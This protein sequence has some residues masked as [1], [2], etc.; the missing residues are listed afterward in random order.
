MTASVAPVGDFHRRCS[1]LQP[2]DI[3][4]S[5]RSAQHHSQ[6]SARGRGGTWSGKRKSPITRGG[7]SHACVQQTEHAMTIE[8]STPGPSL[9]RFKWPRAKYL[10]F[11]LI[12]LMYAYVLWTNES[13]LFN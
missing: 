6:C 4:P 10:L 5:F 11:G 1:R 3:R 12:A 9:Q 7:Q 2:T 8:L 13:F